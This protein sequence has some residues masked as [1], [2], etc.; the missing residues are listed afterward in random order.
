MNATLTHRGPDDQGMFVEGN[1]GL[2]HRRLSIIDVAKGRQPLFNED[3]SVCVVYNGEIYNYREL[4]AE[5]K[6]KGHAFATQCD[7][8]VIPHL[9]EEHG[10]DFPNYMDGMFAVA[11]YD[12]RENILLLARDRLGQKPL[13]YFNSTESFVF[14]SELVALKKNP[15][16]PTDIDLQTVHDYL[17]LQ[18]I[19][20]P[21]TVF[22]G[23]KKVPPGHVLELQIE[24]KVFKLKRYWNL[25]YSKKSDLPF[26]QAK[27]RLRELVEDAVKKRLV[28]DVPLGAFLSGG[29]D[30][31]IVVGL[32]GKMCPE[33]VR[34]FSIGFEENA[35]DERK[36]AHLAAVEL[37]EK[38][39]VPIEHHEKIVSPADFSIIEDLVKRFGEPYSD[40]SMLPTFVLCQYTRERVTVALS[41]DGADEVFAGYYRYLVMKYA[42]LF[43]LL[44]FPARKRLFDLL[45][46]G[47]PHCSEE[48]SLAGCLRRLLRMASAPVNERYLEVINRFSEATKLDL[49]GERFA[50]F[51]PHQT[52]AIMGA[53]YGTTT[54][55]HSV[56]KIMET[57]MHSYLPGDILTKV[58]IASM[59]NSLEVRN[60]FM[61]HHVVE[62]AASLPLKFKQ[63]G[64]TRKHILKEAFRDIVPKG[65]LNREKMGFGVP[66]AKWFRGRWDKELRG[67]L[68]EG[69]S[70][71][72]RYFKRE[73]IERMIQEHQ[74]MK[75][76]HSYSLWALL[77][78]ELFL[79]TQA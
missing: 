4:R 65:I 8:E 54:S 32:M 51:R 33:A 74:K 64:L 40:A 39:N 43:D 12:Q 53:L 27:Q 42:K 19:P 61:D 50:D 58:D 26:D 79:K 30:S 70:V 71:G 35:Y 63:R 72:E 52:Q 16:M 77:I 13:I 34:A 20:S 31:T 66:L 73:V 55:R 3:H 41:G 2:A 56:E 22:Y 7:S 18:Y 45:R 62:F 46:K 69:R 48:R 76:D 67:Q 36:Y 78:F 38:C 75:A 11:I 44:P 47:I 59:A 23:V 17:S 1:V 14:A 10:I 49:Y 9:Y 37:S 57:D 28:S 60:P 15:L 21:N 6:A 5:L 24:K 29:L 68:L 25:D